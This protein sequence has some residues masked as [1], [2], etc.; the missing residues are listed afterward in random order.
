MR[1]N[2]QYNSE[3][4]MTKRSDT[5]RSR[6]D[7]KNG[8]SSGSTR[9]PEHLS[10]TKE[11]TS[12]EYVLNV[13][14]FSFLIFMATEAFFAV[15]AKSQS[16]LADSM[17]MSVDAFTY[18][19]N[20]AAEKLKHRSDRIDDSAEDISLEERRRRKKIIR[21]YLEIVPPAISVTA[22][23]YVSIQTLLEAIATITKPPSLSSTGVDEPN[24]K[25][26]LLFSALNLAL[27][28]LNV[29]C[30]SKVH[31]FSITGEMTVNDDEE[32]RYLLVVEE[33][34]TTRNDSPSKRTKAFPP[35]IIVDTSLD[36]SYES[37]AASE[38]EGL[39]GIPLPNYGSRKSDNEWSEEFSLDAVCGDNESDGLTS[40]GISVASIE[41]GDSS[42]YSNTKSMQRTNVISLDIGPDELVGISEGDE[43]TESEENS[44]SGDNDSE[45]SGRGFNLNMCSAYSKFFNVCCNNIHS[46]QILFNS[47]ICT[48]SLS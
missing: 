34:R 19:F 8:E 15:M 20:L 30:F 10:S 42:S 29:S 1:S 35:S 37:T 40:E 24:V 27:D 14:F 41:R 33:N 46:M 25:L 7:N 43:D 16:M 18:L 32:T 11:E 2:V 45:S 47:T 13:A 26:M 48:T 17:A 12:N 9:R 6:I 36:S 44:N 21:L 31:N 28:M 3:D 22:L 5:N 39:L 4:K 38:N 23:V